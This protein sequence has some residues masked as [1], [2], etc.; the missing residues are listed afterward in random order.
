MGSE[1]IGRAAAAQ[2]ETSAWRACG[3]D[4]LTHATTHFV[5]VGLGPTIYEFR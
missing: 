3:E 5:M 1:A 4:A 2:S